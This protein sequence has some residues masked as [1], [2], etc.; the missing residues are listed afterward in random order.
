MYL[1]KLQGNRILI[2]QKQLRACRGGNNK[3][4]SPLACV[5]SKIA[6]DENSFAALRL[7]LL[8]INQW[9][10]S[11]KNHTLTHCRSSSAIR[12]E[13]SP[14]IEVFMNFVSLFSASPANT[15]SITRLFGYSN[16]KGYI[17]ISTSLSR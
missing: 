8:F 13:S 17:E 10:Q 4:N 15:F 6:R 16:H 7:S 1:T 2:V 14:D 5:N 3:I 11:D 12:F 9:S